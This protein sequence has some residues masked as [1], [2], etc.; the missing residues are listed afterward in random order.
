MKIQAIKSYNK[1]NFNYCGSIQKYRENRSE[2]S[3]ETQ[4]EKFPKKSGFFTHILNE[5]KSWLSSPDA[6]V[7]SDENQ[8]IIR[9]LQRETIV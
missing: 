4:Q 8:Q 7:N 3:Q 6:P 9:K 1:V 2:I 5:L